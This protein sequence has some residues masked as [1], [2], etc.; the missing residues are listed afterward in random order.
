MDEDHHSG[1][2]SAYVCTSDGEHVDV[3]VYPHAAK[4]LRFE[5]IR[6]SLLAEARVL[7]QKKKGK[8][9]WDVALGNM[10]L[11][12]DLDLKPISKTTLI[13]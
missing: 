6:M 10:E 3:Y 9:K 5:R 8:D 13:L 11:Q 7:L 4:K 1:V 12:D 2:A